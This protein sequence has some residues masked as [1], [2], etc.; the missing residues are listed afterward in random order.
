ML[1]YNSLAQGESIEPAPALCCYQK[2]KKTWR[3]KKEAETGAVCVEGQRQPYI[4]VET[5]L[6]GEIVYVE[7][8][9]LSLA[10]VSDSKVEPVEV[11]S[12][13]RVWAHVQVVL[14]LAD[15]HHEVEVAGFELAV[16]AQAPW[17]VERF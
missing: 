4:K 7:L 6:L 13:V 11:S 10:A 12:R 5:L 3:D 17:F 16:E 8:D 15:L 14:L 1:A 2:K 9:S